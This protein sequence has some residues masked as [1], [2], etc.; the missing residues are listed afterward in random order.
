MILC[1]FDLAV[2]DGEG[3]AYLATLLHNQDLGN[4]PS[5]NGCQLAERMRVSLS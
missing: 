2:Y 1:S 3:L 5:A 4:I